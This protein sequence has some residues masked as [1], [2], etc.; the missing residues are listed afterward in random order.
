MAG[1]A[2]GLY[3]LQ[4]ARKQMTLAHVAAMNN[5]GSNCDLELRGLDPLESDLA[6]GFCRARVLSL[7]ITASNALRATLRP[8]DTRLNRPALREVKDLLNY[9]L[10]HELRYIATRAEESRGELCTQ[11]RGS[12]LTSTAR[13]IKAHYLLDKPRQELGGSSLHDESTADEDVDTAWTA[14]VSRKRD[15]ASQSADASLGP[16]I[17]GLDNQLATLSKGCNR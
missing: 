12:V 4:D 14:E 1:I 8:Q 7:Q 16:L 17:I 2:F 15:E 6:K 5:L 3:Q 11:G 13:A 9:E 10:L